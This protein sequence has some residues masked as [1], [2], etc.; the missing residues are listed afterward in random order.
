[1]FERLG[2][3]FTRAAGRDRRSTPPSWRFDLRI[4]EDLIEEVIRVIGYDKLPRDAAAGAGARARAQPEARRSAHA[5]RHALAA[6]GYQETI[7]FSFVE[8]RWERELRRQRRPDPRAQ[9]DRRAAV[10]DAL[11]PDRQPGR[12]AAAQPRAQGR[13]ACACS[14]S[15]ACTVRDPS[16]PAGDAARRRRAPA[17]ARS[18]GLAYGAADAAAVGRGRARGRLLRRQGRSSRRCSRRARCASSPAAHPALHPGPQRARRAR[19]PRASASSAS[20]IRAGARPTSCPAAPVLFE[21]DAEALLRAPVPRFA[22]LPRQ[23]S[24]WR[25]LARR[26]RRRASRHDALMAARRRG[27][28]GAGALGATLFDIYRPKQPGGRHRAPASAAWRVR[29][30]LLRRRAHADRRAHRRA[31]SR[32]VVA[33]AASAARRAPARLSDRSSRRHGTDTEHR[34]DRVILPSLETPTLTKAELAELLFERLGP[35]QARVEGHGRGL[36][37]PRSTTT[38][39]DGRATSSCRASAT[40]TSGA[41][42]RGPGRNPRTGEAIPIKARNVVTFHASHKLKGSR[43][44]RHRRPTEEFE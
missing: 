43:A 44:G 20:C 29:L 16:A 38:L 19:R 35:Q 37:R 30:E 36:L 1:M 11:E 26:R 13:R 41:R 18:A 27:R 31:S 12:R 14:R 21:L 10:G 6:L 5:L 4:E 17:A 3:P 25:D 33:R 15:A 8:E 42:R 32:G 34:R 24:A 28:R 2:L 23:Q 40:S 9:S 39:V 22:P 7:N